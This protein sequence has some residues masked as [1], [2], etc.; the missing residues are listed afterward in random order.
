[1][2]FLIMVTLDPQNPP[3]DPPLDAARF[4]FVST[5]DVITDSLLLLTTDAVMITPDL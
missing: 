1:M 5:D 3:L 2:Q 4:T